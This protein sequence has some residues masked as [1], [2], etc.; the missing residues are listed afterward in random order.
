MSIRDRCFRTRTYPNPLGRPRSPQEYDFEILDGSRARSGPNLGNR[1][2]MGPRNEAKHR[3][4]SPN[5]RQQPK[6][7]ARS[8]APLGRRRRRRLVVF[9]LVRIS[10]VCLISGWP[11]FVPV[12]FSMRFGCQGRF[13]LQVRFGSRGSPV[14]AVRQFTRFGSRGSASGGKNCPEA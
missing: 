5:G 14:H 12:R 8:A 3:K 10:Y 2:R 1:P 4:S 7:A 13:A 6:G 11:R 9:H